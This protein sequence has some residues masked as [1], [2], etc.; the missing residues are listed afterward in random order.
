MKAFLTLAQ[1]RK[2]D[3][4]RLMEK[5]K[6]NEIGMIALKKDITAVQVLHKYLA[7]YTFSNS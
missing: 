1:L 4:V 3:A 5:F 2:C 6:D 7:A